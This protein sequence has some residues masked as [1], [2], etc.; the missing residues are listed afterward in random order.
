MGPPSPVAAPEKVSGRRSV[1]C[2]ERG[3]RR[4]DAVS[5]VGP[6]PGPEETDVLRFYDVGQ[7]SRR[8]MI[9]R[10]SGVAR[11]FRS[12]KSRSDC[13]TQPVVPVPLVRESQNTIPLLVVTFV[14]EAQEAHCRSPI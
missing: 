12:W 13:R 8:S 7:L 2:A 4:T 3:S 14:E 9:P 1:M 5:R 10:S 11:R 6:E